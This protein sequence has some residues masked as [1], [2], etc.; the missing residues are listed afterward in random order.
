MQIVILDAGSQYGKLIDRNIRNLSVISDILPLN[1]NAEKLSKYKGIIISGSPSSLIEDGINFD[2]D[3]FDLDIP[4]LGICYGMQ[5]ICQNFGGTLDNTLDRQD[6][7]F[8][9]PIDNTS[10]L[11]SNLDK[12]EK[13]LLT[14]GDSCIKEPDNFK[15]TA[16]DGRIICAIEYKNIYGI[17]FHPEVNLTENGKQIFHNFLFNI[18]NCSANYDIEN[19][20]Q[21]AINYIK[22]NTNKNTKIICLVSGGVDSSVCVSLLYNA[23]GNDQII[24]IHVDNGFMRKNESHLVE[25]ALKEQGINV[26]VID[27]SEIFYDNIGDETDPEKIRKIIG[28]T[29]I[30]LVEDKLDNDN[31]YILCQGTLRPDLIESASTIASDNACVIKTH[32]N[33]THLVRKLRNNGKV[34]EPLKKYHKDE[35]REIGR[36]LG[37]PDKLVDR[38]PF[39]GPGLAIRV[40][41]DEYRKD[42]DI[43]NAKLDS[44]RRKGF[45]IKLLPIRSVGVQGDGRSYNYV[46]GISTFISWKSLFDLARL[47]TRTIKE[48]N[49]VIYIFGG[50]F[51]RICYTPTKL[52]RGVVDQLRELDDIGQRYIDKDS[53]IAQMPVVLLPLS[54]DMAGKRSVVIRTIITQ[55]FMTGLVA[56]PDIDLR[57]INETVDNMMTRGISRVCYDL[58]CKPPGTTEWL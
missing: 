46:C 22:N 36:K 40:I 7:Q 30:K 33:D 31:N 23:L 24:P 37:L 42:Y 27:G 14:H 6:G 11:F 10:K 55:D 43:I 20:Y 4:I 58:T 48:I 51:D 53:K 17:Q 50:Q 25:R 21:L 3:I 5:I 45:Q 57:R 19:K 41:C 47:V 49:R 39:P 34:I 38:H 28:D 29:F 56:Y 15:V 16:I 52:D 26:T 54:F 18:C 1:I 12:F 35:V 9:I 8:T 32:H 13:V 44:Y 2:Q